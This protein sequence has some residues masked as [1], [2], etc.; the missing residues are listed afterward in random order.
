MPALAVRTGA[1]LAS[2]QEPVNN[3]CHLYQESLAR[4]SSPQIWDAPVWAFNQENL[5]AVLL[6][7]YRPDP[8]RWSN[9]RD[10]RTE[11]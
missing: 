7:V 9:W 6:T 2:L 3:S 4:R 8:G 11:Y 10:R 5:W 1:R